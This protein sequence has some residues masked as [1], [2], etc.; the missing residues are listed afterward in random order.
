MYTCICICK[1]AIKQLLNLTKAFANYIISTVIF[2]R[3]DKSKEWRIRINRRRN[4]KAKEIPF[5]LKDRSVK[6]I[7]LKSQFCN[8][9]MLCFE[10]IA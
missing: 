9:I 8:S 4:N 10:Y 3:V 7:V 6:V 1:V 2:P 5:G